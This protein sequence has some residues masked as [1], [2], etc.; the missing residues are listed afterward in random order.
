VVKL[1]PGAETTNIKIG[2]RVGVKWIASACGRCGK[3]TFL[4][5]F[6][7]SHASY[8]HGQ[9]PLH[10]IH[11]ILIASSCLFSTLPRAI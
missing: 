11:I 2:D 7:F 8:K 1:G 10:L 9:V 5:A 6:S 3:V 4:F